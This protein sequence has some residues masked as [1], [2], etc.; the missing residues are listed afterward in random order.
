MDGE[1]KNMYQRQNFRDDRMG[2]VMNPW[3]RSQIR[4]IADAYPRT[5][6]FPGWPSANP[7]LAA[8]PLLG[9]AMFATGDASLPAGVDPTTFQSLPVHVQQAI[10]SCMPP[11]PLNCNVGCCPIPQPRFSRPA[12]IGLPNICIPACECGVVIETQVCGPF[13]PCTLYV[14]P[15]IAHCLALTRFRLGCTDLLYSCDPVPMEFF[16]CC[17]QEMCYFG[18]APADANA[19]I[20]LTVDNKCKAD[21]DFEGLLTGVICT[22]C[23]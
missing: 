1:K 13:T 23:P 7:M 19:P 20:C 12:I 8:N 14:P 4:D 5:G 11:Q 2:A 16:S 21:V 18:G 6:N 15:K 3:G 10:L 17:D 9:G 22:A